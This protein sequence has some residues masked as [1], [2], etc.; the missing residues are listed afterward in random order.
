MMSSGFTYK[1]PSKLLHEL[2]ITGPEEID[3]EAIAQY[4]GATV[5]YQPLS[6]CDARIVGYEDRAI[7]RVESSAR[8]SRQRFSA[9]HEL[10]HWMRDRR[11]IAFACEELDFAIEWASDNPERRAN[12]FAAD[13]LLPQ[14]FFEP[15]AKD[16]EITFTTAYD[17]AKDFQTSL[18]ATAIRLVT[19]GSF[20]AVITCYGRHGRRWFRRSEDVPSAFWPRD[21]PGKETIAHTLLSGSAWTEGPTE[22]YASEWFDLEDAHRYGIVENSVK[23]T[24]DLVLS[25]L[26]WKNERQL[27]DFDEE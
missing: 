3:V 13:L 9:A 7:I 24:S 27:L 15:S 10:G 6:G 23:I 17:L 16:R 2:G 21:D 18:T 26:W 22:V 20:P 1:S 4:C 25:L 5:L 12:E 14:E 8:R 11:K 19:L